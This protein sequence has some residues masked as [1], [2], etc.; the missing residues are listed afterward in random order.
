M[1]GTE[2]P[3]DYA[4][5]VRDFALSMPQADRF[6]LSAGRTQLTV[7]VDKEGGLE[8][9]AEILSQA[10]DTAYD[11]YIVKSIT[12]EAFLGDELL[13]GLWLDMKP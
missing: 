10:V 7:H 5:D 3:E 6:E 13:D 11:D 4:L 1:Y 8:K 2:S 9:A 12:V